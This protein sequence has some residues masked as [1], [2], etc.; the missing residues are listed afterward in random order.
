[1]ASSVSIQQHGG[2]SPVL[3]PSDILTPAELSARL[4]VKQSWI[5]EQMRAGRTNSLP[6]LRAGRLLRFS[7]TAVCEWLHGQGSPNG[8]KAIR[9]AGRA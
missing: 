8:K 5:Y 7:W 4:K 2:S 9:K 1:M 6:T 3:T